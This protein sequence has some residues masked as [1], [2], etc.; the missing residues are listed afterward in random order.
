MWAFD[1]FHDKPVLVEVV[2]KL[3]QL[4]ASGTGTENPGRQ[5]D[6]GLDQDHAG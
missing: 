6:K 1:G 4:E 5:D 2:G 3:D